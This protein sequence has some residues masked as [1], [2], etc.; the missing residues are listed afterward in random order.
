MEPSSLHIIRDEHTTLAAMLRSLGMMVDRGPGEHPHNFFDVLRSMLFYIDEFPER[1]H[2]PKETELL[3]PKVAERVPET[4]E[5]IAQL[6]REHELGESNVR[7]LQH[8]LLA[9]EL[10]GE[11]RR[12]AFATATKRFLDF[13]LEH[14]RLEETVI[15]P[16]AL[17][18]LSAED[19]KTIDA[20]FE[21]NC[22]PLTGQY[23]RDPIYD[24][25]FTRI[26]NTAP[27]PI[28]LGED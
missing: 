5:L 19:W 18:V 28:G 27:A 7:E 21:T 1:L 4:R 20:A 3:F 8:L 2:H 23:P 10:L 22:D 12:A 16:A 13:Y 24:Q 11:S 6:D 9:W 25:L 15:L 17:K 26:V 14:M